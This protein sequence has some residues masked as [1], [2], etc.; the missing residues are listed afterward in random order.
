MA[1]LFGGSMQNALE[2]SNGRFIVDEEKTKLLV[3][4][5]CNC[6]DY[7]TLSVRPQPELSKGLVVTLHRVY[8]N[9]YGIYAEVFHGGHHYYID[10]RNL[11]YL[12]QPQGG[13]T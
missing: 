9:F 12:T 8:R 2:L 13:E 3:S 6:E 11:E 1:F 5:T 10:P 7:K 4:T